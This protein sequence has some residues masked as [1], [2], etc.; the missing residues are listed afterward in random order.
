MPRP[1]YRVVPQGDGGC[2]VEQDVSCL[3]DF[4]VHERVQRQG[5]GLALF[6]H[7][8]EVRRSA[9]VRRRANERRDCSGVTARG[10]GRVSGQLYSWH[11][12]GCTERRLAPTARQ[13][14][15]EG[16]PRPLLAVISKEHPTGGQG[17]ACAMTAIPAADT[18]LA[19]PCSLPQQEEGVT[20][21][22]IAYDRPSS[23]LRAFLARHFG[24]R[25]PLD[26]PNRFMVFREYFDSQR[27]CTAGKRPVSPWGVAQS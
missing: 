23:K 6:R 18:P 16:D 19:S 9:R 14:I 3:L 21:T 13:T 11:D 12:K 15:R 24:L 10:A 5:R 22:G 1:P 7:A 17:P 2:V 25:S 26:Q 27:H 8:M 4:Y 20:P